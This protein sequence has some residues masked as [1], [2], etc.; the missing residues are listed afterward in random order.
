MRGYIGIRGSS[1]Q[2]QRRTG[3]CHSQVLLFLSSATAALSICMLRRGE[4]IDAN[5]RCSSWAAEGECKK[6]P[7]YMLTS[8][9]L[10]CHSC[11]P[12][13]KETATAVEVAE[14]IHAAQAA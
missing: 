3:S 13:S 12:N 8:C 10:S 7:G 2:S 9:R 1:D 5:E 4:C 6:N 11:S 14:A